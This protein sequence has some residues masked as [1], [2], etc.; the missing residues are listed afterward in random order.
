MHSSRADDFSLD[1]GAQSFIHSVPEK[2]SFGNQDFQI[3]AGGGAKLFHIFGAVRFR[4]SRG[5]GAASNQPVRA[6]KY[7]VVSLRFESFEKGAPAALMSRLPKIL[8]N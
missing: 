1:S 6:G 5:K 8:N 4:S 3:V 7:F 2:V